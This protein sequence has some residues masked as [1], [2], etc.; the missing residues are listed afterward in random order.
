VPHFHHLRHGTGKIKISKLKFQENTRIQ[1]PKTNK[2]LNIGIWSF[3]G[4]CDLNFV[5]LLEIRLIRSIR[6]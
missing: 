1:T 6:N 2:F 5:A 3:S 4:I